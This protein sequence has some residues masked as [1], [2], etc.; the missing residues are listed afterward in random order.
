MLALGS[1]I[2][3][4]PNDMTLAEKLTDGCVWAYNATATGIMPESFNVQICK[5]EPCHWEPPA[6]N[7]YTNLP[8]S[9]TT[10]HITPGPDDL[11]PLELED[12][13]PS[14]Q[15]NTP[16]PGGYRNSGHLNKRAPAPEPAPP[17]SPSRQGPPIPESPD[18]SLVGQVSEKLNSESE[19]DPDVQKL[20][21]DRQSAA[22]QERQ[23]V[24]KP[25]SFGDYMDPVYILRP[26]AIESVFYMYRITGD[27]IWQ[28]KG[29]RMW[30]S[31]EE[32]TW[33]ELAYSAIGDVN[34][35]NGTKTDSMERYVPAFHWGKIRC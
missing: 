12:F 35:V 9:T 10:L 4:R 24:P 27:P 34:N 11:P 25:P 2:L 26:E 20:A 8:G 5:E 16:Q 32:H 3:N 1:K 22:S 17:I 14:T 19:I 7:G 23:R 28:E 15:G 6:D 31:I 30:E 13:N 33:T 18:P 21:V 29:W